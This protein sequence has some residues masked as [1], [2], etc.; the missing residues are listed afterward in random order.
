MASEPAAQEDRRRFTDI[1]WY[2]CILQ[3]LDPST[4]GIW[5]GPLQRTLSL[6]PS[7]PLEKFNMS[8]MNDVSRH[9]LGENGF[10]GGGFRSGWA[11]FNFAA[12]SRAF[13]ASFFDLVFSTAFLLF[14]NTSKNVSAA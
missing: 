1:K 11:F 4:V 7:V 13:A 14:S 10:F 12:R 6:W 5:F 8:P 2:H 3:V 9:A